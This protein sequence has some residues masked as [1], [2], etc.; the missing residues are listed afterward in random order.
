[1]PVPLRGTS[2]SQLAEPAAPA[3]AFGMPVPLRGTSSS[4]LAE[5]AAP[6]R[7]LTGPAGA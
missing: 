7:I 4:Q 6:A 5:P 2:S 3:H 1:M